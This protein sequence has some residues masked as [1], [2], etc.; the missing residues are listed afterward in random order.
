MN[1]DEQRQVKEVQDKVK[2]MAA[3]MRAAAQ[4]KVAITA[5]FLL[6]AAD[7][8]DIIVESTEDGD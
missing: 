7:M 1:E 8:L 4:G 6:E 3:T 5:Q 2:G